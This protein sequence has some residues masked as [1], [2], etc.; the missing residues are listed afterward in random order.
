MKLRIRFSSN[1]YSSNTISFFIWYSILYN[2]YFINTCIYLNSLKLPLWINYK[3]CFLFNM[4]K[5]SVYILFWKTDKLQGFDTKI[6]YYW[7]YIGILT[8]CFTTFTPYTFILWNFTLIQWEILLTEKKSH[9]SVLLFYKILNTAFSLILIKS[10][11]C[12][13]SMW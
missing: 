8:K 1:V 6:W 5:F 7:M 9:I 4:P 12:E 3:S 13:E 11:L 2:C 10:V